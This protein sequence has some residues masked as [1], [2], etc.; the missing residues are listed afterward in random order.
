[1]PTAGYFGK[2]L[3]RKLGVKPGDVV[4]AVDPAATFQVWRTVA[5]VRPP[6]PPPPV[7][8]SPTQVR[9]AAA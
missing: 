6:R 1:M 2:S 7:R 8:S 3:S 9:A 4:L 5:P